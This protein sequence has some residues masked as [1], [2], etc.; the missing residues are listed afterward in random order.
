MI[1]KT[2]DSLFAHIQKD[3]GDTL[4]HEVAEEVKGTMSEGCQNAP[5]ESE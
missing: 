2:L 3:I 4:E 1:C 5:Q